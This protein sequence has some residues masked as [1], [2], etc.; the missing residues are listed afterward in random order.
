VAA[1]R[2]GRFW[3]QPTGDLTGKTGVDTFA[4]TFANNILPPL[5]VMAAGYL[6]DKALGLDLR[7]LSRVCVYVFLPALAA[8]S[9]L[10]AQVP[11][12]E[13]GQI[14]AFELVL[15]ALLGL[16]G[17]GVARLLRYDQKH[18][19]LFLLSTLFTNCGNYGLA[20]VLYAFG[21]AGLARGLVFFIVNSLLLNTLGVYLASRGAF[22]VRESAL[23]VLR[24]P[25]IYAVLLAL[26]VRALGL[27]VPAPLMRAIDLP[28]DGAIPLAQFLLGAQLA[29]ISRRVDLGFVGAAT[30]FRLVV[31]AAMA[32]ALS[33]AMGM[34]GLARNASVIEASMPTAITIAALSMEF[35]TDSQEVGSIVFL[36]TL[37]S[38]V[39]LTLLLAWLGAG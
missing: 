4:N 23:N 14:I 28:H 38:A 9:L 27:A 7:T 6:L 26:A 21:Q 3:Q 24:L 22:G 32:L 31:G 11:A 25:L 12:G 8:G 29:R 34:T 15:T 5:L 18:T 33:A 35:G 17:W 19:N 16:V 20:V 30:F 36:S 37:A 13:Y 39:S 1:R 10:E 2:A